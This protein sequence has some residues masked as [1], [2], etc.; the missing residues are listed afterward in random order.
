MKVRQEGPLERRF[1]IAIGV[2]TFGPIALTMGVVI[3]L[4]ITG[5]NAGPAFEF[6]TP[7]FLFGMTMVG[8]ICFGDAVHDAIKG[9]PE[10][11]WVL[12]CSAWLFFF[13][14]A[15]LHSVGLQTT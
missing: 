13:G 9:K 12:V 3:L 5:N 6:L 2:L 7:A 14:R 15:F 1:W 11:I 8:V 4:A 10:W